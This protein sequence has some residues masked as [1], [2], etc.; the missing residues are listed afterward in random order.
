MKAFAPL[1]GPLQEVPLA[2][3]YALLFFLKHLVPKA[4]GEAVFYTDCAWVASS[5]QAGQQHC[6]HAC[7][8]GPD[9]WFAMFRVA[10]EIFGNSVERLQVQKVKVHTSRAS[11]AGSAELAYLW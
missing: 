8:V 2:E 4:N 5:S 7:A 11:C 1:T 9:I 6:T 10:G 3:A